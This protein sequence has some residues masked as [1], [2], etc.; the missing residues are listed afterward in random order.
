MTRALVFLDLSDMDKTLMRQIAELHRTFKIDKLYVAHYIELQEFSGDLKAH[1]PEMERPIEDIL[2][3]ELAER[4]QDSGLENDQIEVVL[5]QDG[6]KTNMTTWINQSDVDFCVLGKKIVHKGTG[7]FS[8]RMARLLDKHILFT[9]ET[10]RLE[11]RHTLVAVDFSHFSKKALKFSA[12]LQTNDQQNTTAYHVFRLPGTYFPFVGGDTRK[13]QDKQA[14][15]KLKRLRKFTSDLKLTNEMELVVEYA[16]EKT[17]GRT[18]YDY[19]RSH[20]VDLIVMGV[21]GKTD[22]DELLI[23]SVAEQLIDVD[24]DLPVLLVK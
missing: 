9:T 22:K 24:K 17:L 19:A 4:A 1:F 13:L 21:K 6:S 7:I 2:N 15:E 5:F 23:G 14:E 11:I 10:S 3:E 12:Q 18:I 16:G 8:G 20:F